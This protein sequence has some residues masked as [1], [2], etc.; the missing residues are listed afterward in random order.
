MKNVSTRIEEKQAA[1]LAALYGNLSAGTSRAAE[2]FAYLRNYTLNEIKG[3]FSGQ[4]LSALT[5]IFN[6]TIMQPEI[7][8]IQKVMIFHFNKGYK[9]LQECYTK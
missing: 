6:S 7:L 9:R 3:K 5:D 8:L 2:S 4:E 1:M